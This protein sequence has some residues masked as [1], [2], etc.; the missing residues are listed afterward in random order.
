M[1]SE[2]TAIKLTA[3]SDQVEKEE[4]FEIKSDQTDTRVV[5]YAKNAAKIWY[6]TS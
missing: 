1:I 5:L 3:K 4:L 6:Q 2:G